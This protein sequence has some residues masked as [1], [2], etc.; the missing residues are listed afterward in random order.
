MASDDPWHVQDLAPE[1][2][3]AA[4]EAARQ[5]GLSVRQWLESVIAESAASQDA[6]AGRSHGSTDEPDHSAPP[7]SG[8][9]LVASHE[10]REPSPLEQRLAELDAQVERLSRAGGELPQGEAAARAAAAEE[11]R[12]G[13]R[14]VEDRLGALAGTLPA[15]PPDRK[16]IDVL[17]KL[18]DRLDR[19]AGKEST[20]GAAAAERRFASSASGGV[21]P[22]PAA[23]DSGD[24]AVD[25][26]RAVA[27]IIARQRVLLGEAEP[28]APPE[29]SPAM[30]GAAAAQ[31]A[32]EVAPQEKS[33]LAALE[34]R[35]DRLSTELRILREPGG[36]A[37]MIA[38]LR[39]ELAR[40]GNTIAE[41]APRHM[42]EAL[43]A[44][45]RTLVSRFDD[46]RAQGGDA[47]ALESV[48]QS[49]GELCESLHAMKPAETL[50]AIRDEVQALDRRIE[51]AGAGA[52]GAGSLPELQQA[53]AELRAMARH[54]ATGDALA[55]LAANLETLSARIDRLAGPPGLDE[56]LLATLDRRF[57]ALSADI[58]ARNA[59][60]AGPAADDV[61]SLLDTL[62]TK[63]DALE[64]GRDSLP[65]LEAIVQRLTKLAERIE[66]SGARLDQLDHL[67]RSFA[68]LLD[69]MDALRDETR[70]AVSRQGAHTEAGEADVNALRLHLDAL[71]Q[72][73]Q[74]SEQRTQDTLE[75]V[76][77]TLERLIDRL[78]SLEAGLRSDELRA[79]GRG[80][81]SSAGQSYAPG[82]ENRRADVRP[83][84]A[85]RRPIDPTLPADYPLEPGAV[86][87]RLGAS[88]AERIAASE[89][90]LGGAR[91]EPQSDPKA[92]FIAAARRAAQAAAA[93][94]SSENS[95]PEP[96]KG[97]TSVLGSLTRKIAR[98][99]SVLLFGIVL[100]TGSVLAHALLN[101][102]R[103]PKATLV[104]ALLPSKEG[105]GATAANP[106]AREKLEEPATPAADSDSAATLPVNAAAR[107]AAPPK[108]EGP[109]PGASPQA[110]EEPADPNAEEPKAADLLSLPAPRPAA[111]P[112]PAVPA[113][114]PLTIAS[115]LLPAGEVTGSLGRATGLA[116]S[117][118]AGS[119]A[120]AAPA[121]GDPL[122][123]LP[124]R[125][126]AA[127]AAGDPAA[128]YEI[129][130]RFAEG[131]GLPQDLPEAARWFERAA[132]RNFVP[133][134][135]RLGSLYE[136]G[137]GV[138]KSLDQARRLYRAAADAG[139]GKATHN[140]AVLYAEGLEGKPDYGLAAHW[141][142]KA[143]EQGVKD[144]QFNLAVLYARGLGVERNLA[145]S[146]KWFA[147]A[148][149]QGDQ[150]AAKKRDDV[151]AR[152]DKNAI[153][154]ARLA[155]QTFSPAPQPEEAVSVKAPPG[156]WDAPAP[157]AGAPRTKSG[158][159]SARKAGS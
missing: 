111:A 134:L 35:L 42:L 158:A 46:M 143:A 98:R 53:V 20:P 141:F 33:G 140:L 38:S 37:D 31:P 6:K 77:D 131:R 129:G 133:A 10:G 7:L 22:A 159:A 125:L 49:L 17:H 105:T 79:S 100:L 120:A 88:P 118:R 137:E 115:L 60:P 41:A 149:Q 96:D 80:A 110:P 75:A 135:F 87:G 84:F 157:S 50:A 3:E 14:A 48:E 25:L 121:G 148:A 18:N 63:I 43:D 34:Q 45:V 24:W 138:K 142:R 104:A 95:P 56:D 130:T 108:E 65:T 39:E 67:E 54:V 59:L 51:R 109:A 78:A 57:Q 11:V 52:A 97:H 69:R 13:L 106:A 40:I 73:H 55:A 29:K 44:E 151:A 116:G 113:V 62:S 5:R 1:I 83:P 114:S 122:A 21:E 145:E 147:L 99:R 136:K 71:A 28:A 86:Q 94:S 68:A 91:P 72:S 132:T 139:H 92:N 128:E 15:S 9:T 146:Y 8:P 32:P 154:A 66:A 144:S 30:P 12:E 47:R 74:Q 153:L 107:S 102:P 152:L 82:P 112:S 90:V 101:G 150:E 61:V 156:G 81:G 123:A 16:L 2:R 89:A 64:I 155:V 103:I 36:F 93:A 124:E 119:G 58:N 26:D 4:Y 85:E 127:A 126:R 70:E 76:Q 23:A 27:E 19:I 117:P